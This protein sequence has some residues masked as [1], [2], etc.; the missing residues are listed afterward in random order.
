MSSARRERTQTVRI[1]P[2]SERI[3]IALM[4]FFF[5]S[6]LLVTISTPAAEGLASK[7]PND[8]NIE[9][10]P[11]VF[12]ADNFE[13]GDLKKWD[14][15]SGTIAITQDSPNSG[16]Y[17]VHGN[18]PI[19]SRARARSTAAGYGRASHERGPRLAPPSCRPRS[20]VP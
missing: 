13:S 4:K 18:Y 2:N 12:F 1:R 20:R 17:A 5:Q 9:K 8:L 11:R 15:K 10:D 6:F 19:A 16:K 7:Y 14:D 3:Q